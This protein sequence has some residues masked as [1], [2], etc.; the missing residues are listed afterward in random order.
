MVSTVN[1]EIIEMILKRD[2]RIYD[3]NFKPDTWK[4]AFIIE[5]LKY[6]DNNVD[7]IIIEE[8]ICFDELQIYYEQIVRILYYFVIYLGIHESKYLNKI[9]RYLFPDDIDNTIK[10]EN[11]MKDYDSLIKNINPCMKIDNSDREYIDVLIGKWNNE[12]M[13]NKLKRIE[14]I[15]VPQN[16][17]RF[18]IV[19]IDDDSYEE[20]NTEIDHDDMLIIIDFFKEF[21]SEVTLKKIG[22]IKK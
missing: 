3:F 14:V 18:I 20:E 1:K 15:S 22:E 12:D 9:F 8:D 5:L 13:I 16:M 11:L 4:D 21:F 6:Y 7:I 19:N 10:S 17:S 2:I